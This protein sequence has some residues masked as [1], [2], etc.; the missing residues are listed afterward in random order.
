MMHR[1]ASAFTDALATAR[2]RIHRPI[3][4]IWMGAM[5]STVATLE[6]PRIPVFLDIPQAMRAQ[7]GRRVTFQPP[8]HRWE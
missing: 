7:A 2:Q 8:P 1:I 5:E 4:V 6:A 3:V